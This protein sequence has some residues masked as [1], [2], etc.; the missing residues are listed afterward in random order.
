MIDAAERD[1]HAAPGRDDRRADVGQHRHGPRHRRAA[2]GL[3]RHRGHAGQDV[4]REDRPPARLRRRGRRRADER[5]AG[6]AASP[7]TASPSAWPPR[8]PAR[9][10]PTSTST[11]P[12]PPPTTPR[13]APRS[14][15]RSGGR[16]THLVVGVGTGGT[17]T[18]TGRYLKERNP[19]LVIVGAD[20][21][22]SIYSGGEENVKPYLVEGVGED[23]WPKTFDPDDRRPLD[24]GVRP[25]LVPDDPPARDGRGHPRRR[26]RR[27]RARR[28]R[29]GRARARRPR[30][31]RHRDPPGRRAL[32]P[33]QDLQRR[34]DDGERL[35]RPSGRPDRR[36]RAARPSATPARC[37]R[38]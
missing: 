14:G 32:V 28:G 19:D 30:R 25:R 3:P 20:P 6:V 15:S 36:R 16:I 9:S 29:A 18:G 10:S 2:E 38:S 4:A 33:E 24:H 22:G 27:H 34:L 5:P 8:S 21:V 31:A 1:G 12:T 7:T 35:P 17:I 13:P 11:P 23:F 37:R 26:L